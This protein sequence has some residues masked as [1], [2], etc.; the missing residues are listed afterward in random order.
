M[1]RQ[2]S[3]LL[4]GRGETLLTKTKWPRGRSN[5]EYFYS[6]ADQREALGRG[7]QTVIADAPLAYIGVGALH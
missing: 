3:N 1:A 6:L 5:K 4:L 2:R 7:L